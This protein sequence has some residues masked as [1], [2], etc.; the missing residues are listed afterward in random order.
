[1]KGRGFLGGSDEKMRRMWF[2]LEIGVV[3]LPPLAAVNAESSRILD[4]N[5]V[6]DLT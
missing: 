1:M 2:G 3:G 4:S 6:C 5:F